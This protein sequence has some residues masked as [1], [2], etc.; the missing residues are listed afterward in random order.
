MTK[1]N[2]PTEGKGVKEIVVPILNDEYKVIVCWGNS[3]YIRKVLKA[4]WYP[5][6]FT[7][8][9]LIDRRG[10]CFH[11]EK[12]HPVIALPKRPKTAEEIGSLSHEAVHAVAD[13]FRKIE[14]D[15]AEEVYAH[16]VGAI[17]RKTLSIKKSK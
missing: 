4:W 1:I 13:I 16:S 6:D 10:V 5:N 3:E 17:I 11:S 12:C 8:K 7:S 14:Q 9:M 2:K 15:C